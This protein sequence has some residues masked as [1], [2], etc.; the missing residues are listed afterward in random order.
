MPAHGQR[1]G[2]K[3]VRLAEAE[4]TTSSVLAPHRHSEP[5]YVYGQRLRHNHPSWPLPV[6]QPLCIPTSLLKAVSQR[7]SLSMFL[8]VWGVYPRSANHAR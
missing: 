5:N 8:A 6:I 3:R 1:F 2:S 4:G 7:E